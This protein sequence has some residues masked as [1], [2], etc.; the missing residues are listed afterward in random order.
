M[1]N[2]GLA[3]KRQRRRPPRRSRPQDNHPDLLELIRAQSIRPAPA[4]TAPAT[5]GSEIIRLWWANPSTGN[6]SNNTRAEIV[7]WIEN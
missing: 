1:R 5:T 6:T 3:I 7:D 4:S 2:H